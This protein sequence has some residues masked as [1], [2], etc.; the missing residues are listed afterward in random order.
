MHIHCALGSSV[1]RPLDTPAKVWPSADHDYYPNL[2]TLIVILVTLQITIC[3]CEQSVSML[4]LE[5]TAFCSTMTKTRLNG[6][7]MLQYH[8]DIPL[9]ADEVVQEF[10]CHHPRKLLWLTY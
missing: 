10:V 5:K 7:A 1:K 4:Q 8:R 6:L 9:A 2:R 3:E